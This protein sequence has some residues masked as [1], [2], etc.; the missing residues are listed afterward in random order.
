MVSYSIDGDGCSNP[1]SNFRRLNQGSFGAVS[2]NVKDITRLES[3]VFSLLLQHF[4]KI[5]DNLMLLAGRVFPDNHSLVFFGGDI[6]ATS[7]SQRFQRGQ[8]SA[9]IC[10]HETTGTRNCTENVNDACVRNG[11]EISALQRNVVPGVS[12]FQQIV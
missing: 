11:N 12:R 4:A 3:Y 8:L 2:R 6:E 7:K 5:H 10:D 9:V 1:Q